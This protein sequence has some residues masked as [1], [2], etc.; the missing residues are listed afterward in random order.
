M[1]LTNERLAQL[2]GLEARLGYQF[3]DISLLDRALTHRSF[4]HES[5]SVSRQEQH[6]HYESLEFLGDAVLGFLISEYLVLSFPTRREGELSKIK[7]YLVSTSQLS[8][9]SNRLGLQEFLR[10]SRGEEK[11]GGRRKQA[12]LADLFESL[13]GA[14]Y[15]DTGI[16]GARSFVLDQFQPLLRLV[17]DRQLDYRDYKSTLQEKIQG[18]G[19]PGPRYQVIKEEGPD[20]SKQF[21]V[22]VFSGDRE[23]G[24]GRGS[25]KKAAQQ[26]AAR[27]ALDSLDTVDDSKNRDSNHS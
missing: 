9:C 4:A 17:A 25:S 27:T 15:L 8:D 13:V 1:A 19:L 14:L 22:R 3:K 24:E 16:N 7:G 2:Q 6:A 12:I 20:H 10:L 11:T 23:L 5:G 26:E 21:S 18:S